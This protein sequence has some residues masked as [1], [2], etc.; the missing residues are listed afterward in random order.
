MWEDHEDIDPLVGPKRDL[1]PFDYP[2]WSFERMP[3]DLTVMKIISEDYHPY[4]VLR[5]NAAD[6]LDRRWIR[7]AARL[8]RARRTK[9]PRKMPGAWPT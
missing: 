2:D 4:I 7:R 3:T 6:R 5:D 8:A 9:G 1:A